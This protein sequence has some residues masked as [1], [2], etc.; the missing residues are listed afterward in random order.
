MRYAIVIEKAQGNY[1]AYIPDLPGCVA[2]GDTIEETRREIAEAITFHIEGMRADGEP[3]E[4]KKIQI[5]R[6]KT[7]WDRPPRRTAILPFIVTRDSARASGQSLPG[8]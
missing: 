3:M 5:R 2:V 6:R 8:L 4:L 1:S 7:F